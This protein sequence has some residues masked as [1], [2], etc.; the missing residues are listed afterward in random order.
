MTILSCAF[1]F[2]ALPFSDVTTL[3]LTFHVRSVYTKE[4][5]ENF[6]YEY[7]VRQL[8]GRGCSFFSGKQLNKK[9]KTEIETAENV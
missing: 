1:T 2:F 9:P 3:A 8:C 6:L 5:N 7:Y 4:Q